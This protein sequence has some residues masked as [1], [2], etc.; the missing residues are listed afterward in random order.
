[1]H[2]IL[3]WRPVH[4]LQ[5]TKLPISNFITLQ[6]QLGNVLFS[7]S[8]LKDLTLSKIMYDI[9]KITNCFS[10]LHVANQYCYDCVYRI[11]HFTL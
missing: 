5:I 8:W 7:L 6:L 11:D 9:L 4:Y 3:L 10:K 1:M 2:V